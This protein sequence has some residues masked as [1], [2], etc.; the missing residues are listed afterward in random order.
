MRDGDKLLI[1]RSV[2]GDIDLPGGRIDV[3]EETLTL[4]DVIRRE[5][6]EELGENLQFRLGKLLFV[7]RILRREDAGWKFVM[8][9]DAEYL[10]GDIALSQEHASYEWVERDAYEVKQAD[11]FEDDREKYEAFR[12]HFDS[13]K[14]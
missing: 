2:D 3:G 12:D 4:E 1:P 5:V 11:F 6:R 7:Y 10:G 9:Y 14:K 8:V 13:L